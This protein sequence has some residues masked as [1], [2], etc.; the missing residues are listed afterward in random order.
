MTFKTAPDELA[1]I[2]K[3]A[4]AFKR[5]NERYKRTPTTKELQDQTHEQKH[6]CQN[7][8]QVLT[9][10]P[11]SLQ[12][13]VLSGR[14]SL[15][16]AVQR[17]PS[18]KQIKETPV[19]RDMLSLFPRGTQV[20]FRGET[21]YHYTKDLPYEENGVWWVEVCGFGPQKLSDLGTFSGPLHADHDDDD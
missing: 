13:S 15:H 7:L 10:A 20:H 9:R 14:M 17:L 12:N 2:R 19:V 1:K 3:I 6:R 18:S 21:I 16:S 11:L 8:I 5:L 4:N